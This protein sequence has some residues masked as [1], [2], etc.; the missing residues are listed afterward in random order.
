MF[1]SRVLTPHPSRYLIALSALAFIAPAVQAV[2]ATRLAPV[3]VTEHEESTALVELA[4]DRTPVAGA[5]TGE[6]LRRLPG[7]A[8]NSNGPLS[9][10]VQ[11]RGMYGDRVAVRVNGLPISSGGPGGMDPPLH[12]A[13]MP[14]L[15]HIELRRGIA[16]VSDGSEVFGGHVDAK[17]ISSSFTDSREFQSQGRLN[18]SG[19]TANDG[20]GVGT[21]LG[22][23]ND[24]HR[25]HVLAARE[26]ADDAESALGNI[27][28][29]EYE[30]NA[31]GVGYGFRHEGHEFALDYLRNETDNAGTPALPMDIKLFDTDIVSGHYRGQLGALELRGQAYFTQVDHVMSNFHLRQ[32]PPTAA[33]FRT[34]LAES[35]GAGFAFD[36]GR[37]LASGF[38]R[39]G[40]D[41]H[42]AEHDTDIVNPNAA[43]FFVQNYNDVRRQRQSL[44]GEWRATLAPQWSYES[45]LRYTRVQAQSG[46]VDASPAQAGPGGPRVLRDRFNSSDRD[47]VDHNVDAVV[48]LI[49]QASDDLQVEL[50][51]ASKTRA[52]SYQERF[53]W[54]PLESTGGLAD[55]H[56][57]VGN[58]NLDPETSYEVE[59]GLDWQGNKVRIAPRAFYKRVN[60]YIQGVPVVDPVV[61][62]VSTANGDPN[63]LQFANVDA[64][65]FG[66]D[67][68]FE[69]EL[70][71]R[72][73]LD[74][75][76][77]YVRGK[78]RDIDDNLYRIAP[79]NGRVTLS[80]ER[81]HW[82]AHAETQASVRQ[83]KVS[84]SN[85]ET[86][87]GGY[88][89]FNLYGDYRFA[90][91]LSL[92]AGVSNLFDHAAR[93][94]LNGYNRVRDSDVPFGERLPGVGRNV[95]V[96]ANYRW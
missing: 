42:W 38:L 34:A 24:R 10:T 22:L 93:D 44:F 52:P 65:F 80:Y 90:S 20:Y 62:A 5:S 57:Y 71:Q 35:Q 37:A 26:D 48:K 83:G 55:R 70:A 69:V 67:S 95:F 39:I 61:I 87:T 23:A 1:A 28:P 72:W 15:D 4:P 27:H 78:R 84:A 81:E 49:H 43:A 25:L 46:L 40:V 2:P 19:Q 58:I 3:E 11:Y 9:G 77:S 29:T 94:H 82:S 56:N 41:G 53:L 8:I 64:E 16:P 63:P 32:P 59:L 75:T 47:V 85:Q 68:D 96:R 51:L 18:L 12:Y 88:G 50:G 7:G 89:V 31:Y 73:R 17:L 92:S 74:G 30:R 54:L 91:G 66:I 36:G 76:L 13:P 45:G 6:L 86:A 21:V 79:L 60:D 33:A 14:L